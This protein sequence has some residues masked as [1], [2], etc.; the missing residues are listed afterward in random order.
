MNREIKFRVWDKEKNMFFPLKNGMGI[1]IG[2][3]DKFLYFLT[4]E[5]AFP[6]PV[7]SNRWIVQ[8]FTGLKDKN[9]KEIYEGDII[10][11]PDNNPPEYNNSICV[12]E[13]H[14]PCWCYRRVGTKKV[15]SIE[16]DIGLCDADDCA[17]I[18]GNIFENSELLV[19]DKELKDALLK[20]CEH[21]HNQLKAEGLI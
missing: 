20:H 19:T 13:Y 4:N 5:G 2:D 7:E 3:T 8:Q 18:I 1:S 21:A 12:V 15:T 11:I 16:S 17:E 6:I 10:M 14:T 9:G